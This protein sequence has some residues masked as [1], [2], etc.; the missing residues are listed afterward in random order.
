MWKSPMFVQV[1][2]FQVFRSGGLQ[3]SQPLMHF[4]QTPRTPPTLLH[5]HIIGNTFVHKRSSEWNTIKSALPCAKPPSSVAPSHTPSNLP[6][7]GSAPRRKWKCYHWLWGPPEQRPSVLGWRRT[8][9]DRALIAHSSDELRAEAL[10]RSLQRAELR[11]LRGPDSKFR[12][13][14]TPASITSLLVHRENTSFPAALKMSTRIIS[15][16]SPHES[17]KTTTK[18][19]YVF[20]LWITKKCL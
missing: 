18:T 19:S 1:T 17:L 11:D 9:T 8:W 12:V 7:S 4:I 5:A 10:R 14:G 16:K 3:A 13:R 20:F 2:G 15:S 6:P